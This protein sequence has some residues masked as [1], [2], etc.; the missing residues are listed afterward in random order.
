M[1]L[2]H[3]SFVAMKSAVILAIGIKPPMVWWG[4]IKAR[5]NPHSHKGLSCNRGGIKDEI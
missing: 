5:L 4:G 1:P 2:G 3:I